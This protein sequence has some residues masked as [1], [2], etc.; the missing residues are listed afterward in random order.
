M[1]PKQHEADGLL[2]AMMS[3]LTGR[4]KPVLQAGTPKRFRRA[5]YVAPPGRTIRRLLDIERMPVHVRRM[6][7][8]HGITKITRN[9]RCP[10][11]SRVRFKRCCGKGWC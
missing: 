10:C 4:K 6:L 1:N 5:N 9:S 8:V 3:V 2:S 7:A 11:G